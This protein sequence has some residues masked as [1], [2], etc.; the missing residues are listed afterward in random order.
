QARVKGVAGVWK[1][2]TNNVNSMASNLTS[3]VRNIA[4]VVT[5][6]AHGDLRQKV[7]LGARG[8]IAALADTINAMTDTLATFADQV[9]DVAREVG[10]EGKLGGQARVPGATGIWR[11]LTDN[12]NQLAANLTN[13]VRAI[14][15][16]STAVTKGDLTQ[17]IAVQAAGEVA[18]L[19]D[20]INEMIRNLRETTHKNA[21]Q[22][23]LKTNLAK[24]TRML[25]G[26]RDLD[27]V[28]RQILS[29]MA[30]LVGAYQ[31]LFYL[32]YNPGQERSSSLRLLASYACKPGSVPK[33][34]AMGEGIIGQCAV[35]KKRFLLHRIANSYLKVNSGLGETVPVDIAVLPVLFEGEIKGAIELASLHRFSEIHLTFLEQLMESIGIVLNTI[36]ATMRTEDLLKQS[37]S[38][39]Q[40]LQLTNA[41]LEEKARLLSEQKKEVEGKSREIEVARQTVEEKAEQLALTSKYKSQFLANMSHELRTPLNSLLIL[42]RSLVDNPEENLTPK[43]VEFA[44]TILGSGNDLMALINDILDLSKIESGTISLEFNEVSFSDIQD[45]VDRGFRKIAEDKGIGFAIKLDSDLPTTLYTDSKRLYQVLRNLLSNAL[46]FTER[47]S[48]ALEARLAASGWNPNI[49]SLSKAERVVAFAV[50]DTGIGIPIDKQKIIFDAFQQ[51]DMTTSRKYGGTGLGL[52][53]SRQ[54][55]EM[56]G[57]EIRVESALGKGSRFTFYL[58]I[59]GVHPDLTT[60]GF[61]GATADSV[62]LVKPATNGGQKSE[63]LPAELDD[64]RLLIQSGDRTLLIVEDD[65]V[66]ACLIQ[67]SAR[68]LGFKTLIALQGNAG[69][70]LSKKY[71]PSAVTLDLELPDMDGWTILDQIK[72]DLASRH[73]PVTIMTVQQDG[74]CALSQGAFSYLIKP[75]S[76]EALNKVLRKMK[77]YVDRPVKNLLVVEDSE[78]QRKAIIELLSGDNVSVTAVDNGAQALAVL[79]KGSF[80]CMVLDLKLPDMDGYSL[81]KKIKKDADGDRFPI[82]VY[83]GKDLAP[84][85]EQQLRKAAESV[86]IKDARSPERLLDEVSLFL[87]QGNNQLAERKRRLIE[88]LHRDEP[89]LAG[90]TILIV[91][92]DVRNIF[93]LTSVLERYH[94]RVIY[95]EDGKKGLDSLRANPGIRIVLMDVMMP[96]MD[97]YETMREIRRMG[98]FKTLPIIALTAKAM[99]G[100][101][102]KC[103]DAGATDYIPKPVDVERLLSLLRVWLYRHEFAGLSSANK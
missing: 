80:D 40:E 37:Q 12:V 46:K 20:N 60:P 34:L 55:A 29:E 24:F 96:G 85:E 15:D 9:T 22:D 98:E 59:A 53:I 75:V 8:E 35:E 43:Q 76:G 67:E 89:M 21:D 3:Q 61:P 18:A 92:D 63:V 1:D 71:A 33:V 69:L 13:Q 102:E 100:D 45:Y 88:E 41:Q 23:W 51:V 66:C 36:A 83:T 16:V 25:Q 99:K 6:V 32:Y 84:R 19:K 77:E 95:A 2:L 72:Y 47:G 68:K 90:K 65:P 49:E 14:A 82:I 26:Q 5:A 42:A 81:I 10:V 101:R 39:A 58:P 93:A 57:G 52:S 30:P 27:T 86:I 44:K 79:E 62:V 91:D 11:D 38:L 54:I 31:G 48:V 64:D 56:L 50:T 73:I 70:A 7:A 28:S 97:G 78:V 94:M 87:H 74:A 103:I 4:K 17:S